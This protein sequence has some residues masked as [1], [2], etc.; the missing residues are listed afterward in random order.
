MRGHQ[1][2]EQSR[3]YRGI[4]QGNRGNYHSSRGNYRRG[5]KTNYEE[6]QSN[7]QGNCFNT[8]VNMA[9][10]KEEHVAG[11]DQINWLLDSGCTD[12]I[13]NNDIYF[14][15]FINL[16]PPASV[17]LGDGR[18]LKAS[19]IGQ[20][21]TLFPVHDRKSKVTIQN[22][23][24]VKEMEANLIS[25]SRVINKNKIVSTG[26][27]SKIYDK[28]NKVIAIAKKKNR[29]IKM[30]SV[31]IKKNKGVYANVLSKNNEQ[32]LTLKEKW[33]RTL[34]HINFNYLNILCT[35]KLLDGAPKK[36]ESEHMKCKICVENKKAQFTI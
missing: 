16:N 28:N 12:H 24:F 26:H 19:K 4:C 23:F 18:T 35:N 30:T 21:T 9:E 6:K 22:V 33:H 13:I 8:L 5:Y 7:T 15:T 11:N 27:I 32:K 29:L 1:K 3:G 36:L 34:G 20:I 31:A 14:D 25:Y 2:R 10:T 17:K